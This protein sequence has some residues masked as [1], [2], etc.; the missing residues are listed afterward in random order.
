MIN[1]VLHI[2]K[3]LLLIWIFNFLRYSN[4]CPFFYLVISLFLINFNYFNI[5]SM[6]HLSFLCITPKKSGL[7]FHSLNGVSDEEMFLILM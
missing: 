4:F 6:G 3:Y 7:T 5:L 1:E 2:L